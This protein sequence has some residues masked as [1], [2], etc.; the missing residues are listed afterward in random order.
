MVNTN[1]AEKSEMLSDV[2]TI[3][4]QFLRSVRIDTDLGREDAL[5]GYVCQPTAQSLIE[6]MARQ[7]KETRQRAFTWT[8]PYG[9]GKSSLALLLCSLVSSNKTLRDRAFEM[10]S[11]AKS[12]PTNSVFAAN[13]SGW[14]VVPM[15]G[16]RA[17]VQ[18][19]LA[20]ALALAQ[21][22]TTRKKKVLTNSDVIG[23]LVNASENHS[24]GVL[25][26]IDEMGK[27]LEAASH[28]GGDLH[29]FQDLAE[30][31]SRSTGKLI[32]VGILHQSFEAYAS[33]LGREARDEWAKV[34]GRFI[35][36]PMVA[37]VDEVVEL[38]GRAI[39]TEQSIDKGNGP[40]IATTVT[41]AIIGRRPITPISITAATQ[42]CWPLHPVVA[43]LLGPIS[44]RRFSQNERSTFGFLA[45][46][47][48]VGFMEFLE[49]TP[50]VDA[51]MYTPARYWD[52]LKANLDQAIL[53]SPDGHRWAVAAE[54]VER[55][56]TKGT[57][58]HIEL[59]KSVALIELFRG[60]SG[61]V[62]EVAVLNS[63]IPEA[64]AEEAKAILHDLISW[65]ILIERKHLSAFGV[66]SGSDFDIEGAINKSVGE[67]GSPD[68]QQLSALMDM[69]P[70]LAKRVYSETG[71]M[72]WF[73]RKL[74]R[75]GDLER[76]VENFKP[77]KGSAG[78]F[79]LCLPE[80]EVGA[81]K[82]RSR[83][84]GLSDQPRD[85]GFV[86]GVPENADRITE[87]GVELFACEHVFKTRTE[88]DGDSVARKELLG[89]IGALRSSLEDEL[90]DAYSM[91][92]WYWQGALQ[93]AIASESISNIAS[94]IAQE[95][96]H[97]S[98]RLN[99]ELINR[100]RPSSN[101]N[102]ARKD[103]MYRMLSHP[104]VKDMGY[105]GYPADKGLYVSIL[106]QC[107][108]HRERNGHFSFGEPYY[109][110]PHDLAMHRLWAA[111]VSF[112]L[113][114][115]ASRKA[116]EIY[117]LWAMPPYGLRQG[118][119]PVLALAF[120]LA[121]R[122]T[123]ALYLNG[124]FTS[125]LTEVV[126]DEWLLDPTC[127]SFSYVSA[128][129]D[130][131]AY[132][133][134]IATCVPGHLANKR[135]DDPLEVARSLVALV[136]SLPNWTKRT[137]SISKDAQAIR[138]M[139]LK[140]S[141]PIKVLFSDLPTLLGEKSLVELSTKLSAVVDEFGTSYQKV[142]ADVKTSLLQ[143]LDQIDGDF[144]QLKCRALVVKGIAGEFRLEAFVTRLESFDGTNG[145][146]ESLISLA[147]SKVPAQF[148]DRDIDVAMLQLASWAH[149]FR[150]AETIAPLRGRPSSRRAIGV[151]FGGGMGL[152]ASAS[153]D[154]DAKDSAMVSQLASKLIADLQTQSH[155]VA[156]AALAEAGALLLQTKQSEEI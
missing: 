22:V 62:P 118:V 73:N 38:V 88:L 56:E 28:E 1:S 67:L 155:E 154:I 96:Y 95:I 106:K 19:E 101:S 137:N 58:I 47:E 5:Q 150:R 94:K 138:A 120:F 12:S 156:L 142:L 130:Q 131:T 123:L 121:N 61:L 144:K 78:T 141:D 41:H 111:T 26:V 11:P 64:S 21:G 25:V 107:G 153:I 139:L 36:M 77:E 65:K 43:T 152:E 48:P 37:A 82:I 69:Q 104:N 46:R 90:S 145:A 29:F 102:R 84:K 6:N 89:R 119:M 34:Q 54:A 68:L 60:G 45:S 114:N 147:T 32:V 97:T 30:A 33:R 4:R 93:N 91:S 143:A 13:G 140:A 133:K 105:A 51:P 75:F 27:L 117:E 10:L 79:L 116:S 99:N 87:L 149:D 57:R 49:S 3:S 112:V 7:V 66:F 20:T 98:P 9:G 128:S 35:D 23:E 113:Q 76:A 18:D 16:K 86:L 15:V 63:C 100:E 108:L 125:E 71:T 151:V 50:A 52:Y 39:E 81:A 85:A 2:V 42:R 44:R 72:R 8:G 124:A 136:V 70:I 115:G 17:K 148:V 134:A 53:A 31:A 74:V 55:A 40:Q 83:L 110:N 92:K 146:I 127:V 103:L 135:A 132:L 24:Q 126:I 122:S 59:T 80:P 109:I 14:L 129:S